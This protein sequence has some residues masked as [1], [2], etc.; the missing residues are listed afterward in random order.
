MAVLFAIVALACFSGAPRSAGDRDMRQ[1]VSENYTR[2]T[3]F[4]STRR[5]RLHEDRTSVW[6]NYR[7]GTKSLSIHCSS[8]QCL[9]AV[10]KVREA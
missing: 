1:S 6:V 8:T 7:F 2:D 5:P 9:I 3:V 10:S 4:A